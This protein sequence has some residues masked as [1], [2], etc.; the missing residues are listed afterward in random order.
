MN[1]LEFDSFEDF[2]KKTTKLTI[3]EYFN[4]YITNP[5]IKKLYTKRNMSVKKRMLSECIISAFTWDHTDEGYLYWSTLHQKW[6]AYLDTINDD[7][8][9]TFF[10]KKIPLDNLAIKNTFEKNTYDAFSQEIV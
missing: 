8:T 9:I 4:R 7:N 6:I 3:E 10:Q 5:L 1:E 2:L